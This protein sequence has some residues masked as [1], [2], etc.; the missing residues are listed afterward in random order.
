MDIMSRMPMELLK[1]MK[2]G[3]IHEILPARYRSSKASEHD[4]AILYQVHRKY[5]D[6]VI[7][8]YENVDMF[9]IE[10]VSLMS[11]NYAKLLNPNTRKLLQRMLDFL[12][13]E[14]PIGSMFN[15]ALKKDI[16]DDVRIIFESYD[17]KKLSENKDTVSYRIQKM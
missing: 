12:L 2:C 9:N 17:F 4:F 6:V 13:D 5:Q 1:G 10:F 15:I 16:K 11:H 7:V 8:R 3:Q 14:S